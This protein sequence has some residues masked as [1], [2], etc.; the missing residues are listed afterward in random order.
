MKPKIFVSHISEE[1]ELARVLK[2]RINQDF[3]GLIDVFAS[4]D[5]TSISAGSQW[6]EEVKK[7]LKEA[8]IELST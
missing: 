2:E 5:L 1:A 7:A 8:Q 6:L 3:L 4:T